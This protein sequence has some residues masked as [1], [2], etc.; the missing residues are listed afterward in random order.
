M[1][2]RD[3]VK[4]INEN[5]KCGECLH[6]RRFSPYPYP[7]DDWEVCL[8]RVPGYIDPDNIPYKLRSKV[9]RLGYGDTKACLYFKVAGW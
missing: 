4:K 8:R 2:G 5:K 9:E 6:Y 3:E 7:E 1:T